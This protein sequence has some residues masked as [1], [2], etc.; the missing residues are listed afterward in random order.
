VGA[1]AVVG[2]ATVPGA[3][4]LAASAP[5]LAGTAVTMA[6]D[7]AAPAPGAAARA[8]S[9]LGEVTNTSGRGQAPP[10]VS[11]QVTSETGTAMSTANKTYRT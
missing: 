4:G 7:A 5:G 9:P 3:A 11:I 6:V 1:T 8:A 2:A 10:R